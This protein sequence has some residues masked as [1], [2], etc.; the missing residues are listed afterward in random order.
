MMST[1]HTG[2]LKE[3]GK[4]HYATKLPIR[5]P[6]VIVSYN[7]TMGGVDNLSRV[8]VPYALA[9]KGVKWYRKLAEVFIDFAIYNSFV[10]LKKLNSNIRTNLQFRTQLVDAIIMHHL[11]TE[12]SNRPGPS[13]ANKDPLRLK[14]KHFISRIS[15]FGD[16][17]RKRKKCVR[18]THMKKRTDTSFQCAKCS[19]PLCIEPC[20][21]IYHTKKNYHIETS[22]VT[23]TTE[24]EV[25]ESDSDVDNN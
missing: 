3:S 14:E 8:L 9:R 17:N 10:M 25:T 5:K 12:D 4:I 13:P 23:S 18:C 11:H 2:E 7:K 16:S 19:V 1:K 6:D 21:E 20:F 22:P 24:E 15:A